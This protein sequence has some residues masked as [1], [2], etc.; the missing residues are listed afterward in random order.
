MIQI[1]EVMEH[2]NWQTRTNTY[3]LKVSF[4]GRLKFLIKGYKA[5]FEIPDEVLI[6]AK[7]EWRKIGGLDGH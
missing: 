1:E 5:E 3:M 4:I 7:H 2:R 6:G